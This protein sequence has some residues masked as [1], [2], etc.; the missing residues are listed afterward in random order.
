[1]TG[2]VHDT[3]VIRETHSNLGPQG[4]CHDSVE[5]RTYV[6][7]GVMHCTVMQGCHVGC[8]AGMSCR[9]VICHAGMSYRKCVHD[10]SGYVI[11]VRVSCTAHRMTYM[12]YVHDIGGVMRVCHAGFEFL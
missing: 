3:C 1:M 5:S 8:H 12:G 4:I 6:M 7:Q 2:G 11:A 9:F 10:I